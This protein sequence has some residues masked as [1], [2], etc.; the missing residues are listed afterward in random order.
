VVELPRVV[1]EVKQYEL[2][3]GWCAGCNASCCAPLPTGAPEGNF[4]P[5]LTGFIVGQI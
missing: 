1:P 5:R 3:A 2:H 4:G